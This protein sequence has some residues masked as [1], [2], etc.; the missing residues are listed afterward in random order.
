MGWSEPVCGQSLLLRK[1]CFVS[2]V[3]CPRE[4]TVRE[5]LVMTLDSLSTLVEKSFNH[6][7]FFQELVSVELLEHKVL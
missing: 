5:G 7:F 6:F 2:P 3:S 4:A 1:E